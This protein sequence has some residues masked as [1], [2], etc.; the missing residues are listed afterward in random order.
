MQT[1]RWQLFQVSVG[2]VTE[3]NIV[4]QDYLAHTAASSTGAFDGESSLGQF[5][6]L[7]LRAAAT[8]V[9]NT[10]TGATAPVQTTPIQHFATL[11]DNLV[12]LFLWHFVCSFARGDCLKFRVL[13]RF[14]MSVGF[15]DFFCVWS[16]QIQKV[17]IMKASR[18]T[19]RRK[20]N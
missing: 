12:L 17:S 4:N 16:K 8:A 3:R 5:I 14:T 19:P 15:V 9:P 18:F 7:T 2:G 10:A 1:G 11:P 13:G 20:R 6:F